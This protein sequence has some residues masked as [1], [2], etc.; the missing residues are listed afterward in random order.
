M[1]VRGGG[2][3]V[4]MGGKK[5]GFGERLWVNGMIWVSVQ[6]GSEAWS[7]GSLLLLGRPNI[8][9]IAGG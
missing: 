3:L 1:L 4:E 8:P 2:L 5:E 6:G 7:H 9:A